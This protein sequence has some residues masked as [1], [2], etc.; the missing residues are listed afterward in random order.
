[1]SPLA[2][3]KGLEIAN[4]FS[5]GETTF[6]INTSRSGFSGLQP[7]NSRTNEKLEKI[8]VQREK[9]DNLM[10]PDFQVDFIKVDVEGGELAVLRGAVKTLTRFHPTILFECTRSGLSCFDLTSREI[11]EFFTQHSYS[12]F[13]LKDFLN[14]SKPLQVEEFDNALNYPFLGF[15]FIAVENYR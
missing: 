3:I 2:V 1:M 10:N 9:L 5:Y 4:K 7:H 8:T 6:Y 13:L 12:I 11:F 15:N 14:D